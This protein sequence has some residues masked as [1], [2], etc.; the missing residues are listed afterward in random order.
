MHGGNRDLRPPTA[1]RTAVAGHLLDKVPYEHTLISLFSNTH[2]LTHSLTR[3]HSL[4]LLF[5]QISH[6]KSAARGTFASLAKELLS[7]VYVGIY[8]RVHTFTYTHAHT[9]TL[10]HAHMHNNA[11]HAH[12]LIPGLCCYRRINR[13]RTEIISF[14]FSRTQAPQSHTT[15]ELSSHTFQWPLTHQPQ[16][17]TQHTSSPLQLQLPHT[18]T[19]THTRQAPSDSLC[20]RV[21]QSQHPLHDM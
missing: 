16:P 1:L 6:C 3:T 9:H 11:T 7:A 4:C 10:S 17:H 5:I 21:P 8:T 14:S 19:H 15:H 18:Y 12:L 2:S 20:E 13:P